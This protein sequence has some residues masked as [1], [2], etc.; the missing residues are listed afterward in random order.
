MKSI[1]VLVHGAFAG[2]YAWELITP[3]LQEDGHT[4]VTFDLPG[5]GD[6]TTPA[7]EATFDSYVAAARQAIEAQSGKVTLVGHSMG[8]MVIS[9][10]AEQI[11]DKLDKL[12]Y[13]S[14]Y[15]PKDGD[16]LQAL[17]SAD[18]ESLIGPNLQFAPDYSGA[19]LPDAIAEQVFAGDCPDDIKQLVVSKNKLEPLGAFQTKLSLTDANFGSVPKYYVETLKDQGVGNTLQKKMVADNGQVVEVF[20][21]DCGHS[22]YFAKPAELA[23]ILTN[24]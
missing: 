22:P 3:S 19:S 20:S 23:A 1:L 5:H 4:V 15:L 9:A 10:V 14:A 8:G 16:D 24:L 11:P 18:A 7:T 2:A 17:A 6:D 21:L 13:L 12:V